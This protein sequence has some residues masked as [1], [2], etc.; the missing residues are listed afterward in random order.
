MIALLG[1]NNKEKLVRQLS[2]ILMAE[3][4]KLNRL[5]IPQVNRD[6]SKR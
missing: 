4:G 6:P 1:I 5:L 3:N 2:I